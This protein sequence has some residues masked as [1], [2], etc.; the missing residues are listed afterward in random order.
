[1]TFGTYTPTS[2]LV[3][4]GRFSRGFLNE[5]NGN[6][7]VPA[8]FPQVSSCGTPA[9]PFACSPTGAN[10]ITLKDI[11]LRTSYEFSASYLFNLGGRH[12]LKG[13]YQRY[14][15]FNDVQSGNNAI[16]QLRFFTGTPISSTQPE[17]TPRERLMG[18]F[19]R[20]GTNGP[21]QSKSG[22]YSGCT[23][24]RR[25]LNLGV[26]IEKENLPSFNQYPRVVNF[27]WK[28]KVARFVRLRPLR[29]RTKI[30]ASY[31]KFYDRVKLPSARFVR[32]DVFLKTTLDIRRRHACKF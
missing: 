18:S 13:G 19:R 22:I 5:K 7:F 24:W 15:I 9:P 31:G 20:Q 11:S 12:E 23:P 21:F 1:M 10:S 6:Y 30:F 4:D 2:N 3:I 25:T 29:R 32:G 28:D 17:L 27:D 16:G 14:T 8:S 26:R